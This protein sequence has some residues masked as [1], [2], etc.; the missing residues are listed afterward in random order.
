MSEDMHGGMVGEAAGKL[1]RRG[2]GRLGRYPSCY[3]I[4]L[5]DLQYNAREDF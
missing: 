2:R 4:C 1:T 3:C 5:E